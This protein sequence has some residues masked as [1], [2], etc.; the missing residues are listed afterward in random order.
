MGAR[1]NGATVK[2][3]VEEII[4]LDETSLAEAVTFLSQKDPDLARIVK[5][6]GPPPLWKREPGFPTLVYLILEQQVSLASA[7]ASYERLI[8]VIGPALH[9]EAFLKLNA[10]TLKRIGFSRQKAGYCRLLAQSILKK[11]LDLDAVHQMTDSAA[12]T[13]L[14]RLK[15]IGPWTADVYLLTALRRPDAW[16]VGDLALQ[17][18]VR[19]VK[20]LRKHPSPAKLE[21][22]GRSWRPWRAVA[23]R[24]LW[25]EYLS[26]ARNQPEEQ[27]R[28]CRAC[29]QPPL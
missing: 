8:A 21:R 19:R 9:P 14:I 20:R 5:T 6:L 18:A 23:A 7:K 22:I 16:P 2:S 17:K 29:P 27:R 4:S 24:L 3:L 12:R 13:E 1:A 25:H 11:Q 28:N 10:R 26:Q 15:G